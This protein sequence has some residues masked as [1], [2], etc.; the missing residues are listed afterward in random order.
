MM[1]YSKTGLQNPAKIR[2]DELIGICATKIHV[3]IPS[4]KYA[5]LTLLALTIKELRAIFGTKCANFP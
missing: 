3:E 2:S 1:F 4:Q 5:I